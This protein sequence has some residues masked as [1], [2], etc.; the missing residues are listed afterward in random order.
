MQHIDLIG[1]GTAILANYEGTVAVKPAQGVSLERKANLSSTSISM[2][3]GG[4]DEFE[5]NG[6]DSN[7]N[8]NDFVQRITPQPQ[9]SSSQAEPPINTGGNGTGTASISPSWVN[10]SETTDITIKLTGNGINTT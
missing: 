4:I 8:L 9:N 5:G 10:T 7:N 1:W 3:I 6:N 2:A